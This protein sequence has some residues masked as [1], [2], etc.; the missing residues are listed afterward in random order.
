MHAV[1]ATKF[2][3]FMKQKFLDLLKSTQRPGIDNLID[4]LVNKTDFFT[5][6]ASTQYHDAVEGGLLKHSLQVYETLKTVVNQFKFKGS[7]KISESNLIICGLLHDVCKANFYTTAVK[8]VKNEA[9]G[10]WDKAPYIT[11][12]DQ[13]PL[14]HGEKSVIILQRLVWLFD[15]ELMAIRW[16]MAGFDD[17]ARS[18]AGGCALH[19]ALTNYP[20]ISALH[21]ADLAATY[22]VEE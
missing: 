10:S 6:P 5:A 18:Y 7:E 8:N 21:I 9:T 19:A 12:N 2:G 22:L 1:P 15:D 14:G 16:H 11:I 3:G 13:F 4:Y 17:T 20:L